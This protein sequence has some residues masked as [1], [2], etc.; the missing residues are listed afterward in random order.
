MLDGLLAD[1]DIEGAV[2]MAAGDVFESV[3]DGDSIATRF[4]WLLRSISGM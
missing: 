4:P 2:E 1:V 3:I